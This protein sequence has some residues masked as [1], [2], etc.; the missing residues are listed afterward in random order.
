MRAQ[1]HTWAANVR[2]FWGVTESQDYDRN[3][4]SIT[5][6]D[7]WS[8]VNKCREDGTA[9]FPKL[10]YPGTIQRES[11][12]LYFGVTTKGQMDQAGWYCAQRRPGRGLGWLQAFYEKKTNTLPDL[13]YIVDDDTAVVRT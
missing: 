1:L 10:Y 5:D 13:L 8:F 4:T 3:C 11:D 9:T 6:K 12:W 7:L 2:H